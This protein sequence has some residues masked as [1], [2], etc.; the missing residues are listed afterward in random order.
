SSQRRFRRTSDR[1]NHGAIPMTRLRIVK[2]LLAERDPPL[3][4]IAQRAAIH[5]PN[6]SAPRSDGPPAQRPSATGAKIENR[7]RRRPLNAGRRATEAKKEGAIR[8]Q[9]LW[10]RAI[11]DGFDANIRS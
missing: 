8:G 6:T 1:T 9:F 7:G 11:V 10:L 4:A 2:Q 3:S 5:T